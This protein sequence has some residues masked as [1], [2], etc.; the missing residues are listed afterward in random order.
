MYPYDDDTD[1]SYRYG[2]SERQIRA[3]MNHAIH[4]DELEND[5]SLD[6]GDLDDLE[7]DEDDDDM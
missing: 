3:R 7:P 6:F 1:D 5:D 4:G 2:L